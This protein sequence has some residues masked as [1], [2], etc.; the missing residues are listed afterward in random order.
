MTSHHAK[1]TMMRLRLTN[2]ELATNDFENVSVMGPQL[3]KEYRNHRP[4]DWSAR[5]GLLQ[6]TSMLKLDTLILWEELKQAVTKLANG[7][8]PGLNDV[9]ADA[10]K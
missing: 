4:V 5:H 6:R 1:P 8:S 10:F 9:P 3:E 2:G 7:K